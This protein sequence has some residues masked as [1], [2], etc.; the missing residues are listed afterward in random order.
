MSRARWR[1]MPFSS[2][3][4]YEHG[5]RRSSS[6][7]RIFKIIAGHHQAR[8]R[9][10]ATRWRISYPG[11]WRNIARQKFSWMAWLRPISRSLLL[12]RIGLFASAGFCSWRGGRAIQARSRPQLGLRCAGIPATA[13]WSKVSPRIAHTEC[14][15]STRQATVAHPHGHRTRGERLRRRFKR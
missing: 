3:L 10:L 11:I 8:G 2:H 1:G 7:A 12:L 14:I 4:G 5:H 13:G 15:A 9:K 6:R